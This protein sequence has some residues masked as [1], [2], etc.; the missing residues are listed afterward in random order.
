MDVLDPS[1]ESKW[2]I[3]NTRVSKVWGFQSFYCTRV[4]KV[5]GVSECFVCKSMGSNFKAD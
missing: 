4:S 2:M 3:F 5:W 1:L